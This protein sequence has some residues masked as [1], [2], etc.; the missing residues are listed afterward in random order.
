MKGYWK[1]EEDNKASF[2]NGFWKSGDMARIDHEG[3]VYIMDR[4][5]DMINRGGEKVFS[6][7]VE[8]ILYGHPNVLEAAVVGVPDRLFGER[9]KAYIVPKEKTLPKEDYQTYLSGRLADYKVPSE[10]ETIDQ[11]PRNPGGKVLKNRLS[12]MESSQV[13]EG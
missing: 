2:I 10:I 8:N 5:K 12:K 13:S 9:V 6:A 3:Y 7:E 4:K 1:N 11:L